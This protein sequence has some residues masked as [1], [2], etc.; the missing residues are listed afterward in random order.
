MWYF[1]LGGFFLQANLYGKMNDVQALYTFETQWLLLVE[2]SW[3]NDLETNGVADIDN[4]AA[5]VPG[6][7]TD[8]SSESLVEVMAAEFKEKNKRLF[9]FLRIHSIT[10]GC[11]KFGL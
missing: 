5:I 7:A 1:I 8:K 9:D 10:D 6:R 11:I 4:V 2:T 3:L